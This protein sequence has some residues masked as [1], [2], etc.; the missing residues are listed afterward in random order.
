MVV[1]KV[2]QKAASMAGLRAA[3]KVALRVFPMV[4]L[5]AGCWVACLVVQRAAS[6]V[7]LRAGY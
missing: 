6:T 2:V 5:K 4:A 7:D 3:Q 1:Q